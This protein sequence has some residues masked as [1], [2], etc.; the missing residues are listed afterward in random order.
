MTS[1]GKGLDR[2]FPGRWISFNIAQKGGEAPPQTVG[3]ESTAAFTRGGVVVHRGGGLPERGGLQGGRGQKDLVCRK[4]QNCFHK[5]RKP[6]WAARKKE[7]TAHGSEKK[8]LRSWVRSIPALEGGGG[9]K[10]HLCKGRGDGSRE[11]VWKG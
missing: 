4:R 7:T 9:E 5:K 8:N 6:K 10:C 1:E 2:S 3:A 11:A